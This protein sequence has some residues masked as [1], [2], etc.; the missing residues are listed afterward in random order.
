MSN[1]GNAAVSATRSLIVHPVAPTVTI[2]TPVP[3]PAVA[4]S[5]VVFSATIAGGQGPFTYAWTFAGGT[6]AT[7]S[8]PAPSTTFATVTTH[9]VNL[10]VTDAL[11]RSDAAP[12]RTVTVTAP[13]APTVTATIVS[14]GPFTAP[15]DVT[16]NAVVQNGLG[17]FTYSWPL[18]LPLGATYVGPSNTQQVVIHFSLGFSG[19]IGVTV[20]DSLLRS[21]SGTVAIVVA[22]PP[23]T[24]TTT[25]PPPPPPTT[26]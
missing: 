3:N 15:R 9:Q 26:G 2:N 11:G 8:S 21:A 10:T 1:P 20:F 25:L 6:P 23:P 12:Q 24:T 5:P 13:P 19:T 18:V 17:P 4:G 7:S 14:V 16:F 22:A